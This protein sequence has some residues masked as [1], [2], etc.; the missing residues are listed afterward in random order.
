MITG[1]G[2]YIKYLAI[3]SHFSNEKYDYFKYNGQVRADQSSFSKRND[4]YFFERLAKKLQSPEEI[5]K[6]FVASLVK[7]TNAWIGGV[8]DESGLD[9]YTEWKKKIQSITYTFKQELEFLFD[10]CGDIKDAFQV[11]D[12]Q[13]PTI[14]KLF[15]KKKITIET[16]TILNLICSCFKYWD[17][18]IQD[19]IVW[20][21]IMKKCQKY[22]PF[23][24]RYIGQTK[25][26]DFRNLVK[27]KLGVD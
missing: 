23:L 1:F 25:I 3:K 20:P 21:E 22:Q 27:S 24:V 15:L 9:N 5:E 2:C 26:P 10:E 7:D 11:K 16:L 6:F 18:Q 4:R 14:L 13:H 12:G 8:L 19:R 17:T